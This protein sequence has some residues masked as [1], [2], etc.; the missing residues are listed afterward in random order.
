[1]NFLKHIRFEYKIVSGY[2]IIGA[3]WILLSD[4]LINLLFSEQATRAEAQLFKGWF[5]ILITG[6]F[7]F[8][9][10]RKFVI[11]KARKEHELEDNQRIDQEFLQNISHEVRTPLNNI[12]GFTELIQK[13]DI[14]EKE[15]KD[16]LRIIQNSSY[17][18]LSIVNDIIDIS[19]LDYSVSELNEEPTNLNKLLKNL[20]ISF[21]EIA[22]TN[23]IKFDY[24]CSLNKSEEWVIIDQSKIQQILLS[25]IN[26]SFKVTKSGFIKIVCSKYDKQLKFYIEDTGTIIP[27]EFINE[28]FDN[29]QK[30]KSRIHK[31]NQGI[32]IGLSI[33][34]LYLDAMKGSIKQDSTYNI[35]NRFLISIPYK[36]AIAI[37][38]KHSKT[39]ISDTKK[40]T[41]LIAEDNELNFIYLKEL[42]KK[43]NFEVI[44]A[45]NGKEA[46]DT[47]KS[48]T[49]IGLVFMDI[50]MPVLNGYEATEIIK[51]NNPN[52]PVIIQSAYAMEEDLEFAKNVGCN[53]YLTKPIN[54]QKLYFVVDNLIN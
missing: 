12:I 46:V 30:L 18:L 35:G 29:P 37:D 52:L 24:N 43:Y 45:S 9:F 39:K 28:I 25:L 54:S 16:Y 21:D 8:G 36:K 2:I 47:C 27:P 4:S 34:K 13:N 50:K 17:N 26:H 53:A 48:N 10:I 1:M 6:C 7:L 42:L 40:T 19:Q 11:K 44:R 5:F 15:R 38:Q 23:G 31:I 49:E 14:N 3:L 32:G 20:I 51:H 41:V 22:K 33:S